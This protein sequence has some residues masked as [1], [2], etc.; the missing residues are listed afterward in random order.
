M[1]LGGLIQEQVNDTLASLPIINQLPFLKRLLGS[2]NASVERSEVLVMITGHIV[3]ERSEIDELVRRYN[4][5]VKALNTYDSKLGDHP[6][7][8]KHRGVLFQDK[9]FWM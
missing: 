5:A 1:V 7:A 2:T 6:D 3:N 9:E 4:D 8:D